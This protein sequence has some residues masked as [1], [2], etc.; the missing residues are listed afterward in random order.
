ML[1][2]ATVWTRTRGTSTIGSCLS[3]RHRGSRGAS[4][5]SCF[6]THSWMKS[7]KTMYNGPIAQ[8]ARTDPARHNQVICHGTSSCSCV[9]SSD[10]EICCCQ[11]VRLRALRAGRTSVQLE[12]SNP[13]GCASSTEADHGV[14]STPR[15]RGGATVPPAH[16]VGVI[17]PCDVARRGAAAS[18]HAEGHSS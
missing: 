5:H 2:N 9:R 3:P 7:G 11:Q 12:L 4:S 8:R 13:H 10:T 16:D 14:E 15:N 6:Y 17:N 1:M 18:E